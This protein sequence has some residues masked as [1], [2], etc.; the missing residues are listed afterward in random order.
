MLA[1]PGCPNAPLLGQRLAEA[2]AGRPAVTVVRRVVTDADEA[3]RW[4]MFGSPTPLIGGR[5]RFAV[6]GARAQRWRAGCMWVRTGAWKV[7]PPWRRCGGALG[8]A[9]MRPGQ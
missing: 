2:L 1:A 8:P 7:R 5:D 9:G 4:G 3:A 6:P